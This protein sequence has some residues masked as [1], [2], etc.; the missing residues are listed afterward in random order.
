MPKL[1]D[2]ININT[3]KSLMTADILRAIKKR[4]FIQKYLSKPINSV[5]K[6]FYKTNLGTCNTILKKYIREAKRHITVTN[7]TNTK[8]DI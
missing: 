4:S 2:L 3:K 8:K 6:A 1:F 7:S 5:E